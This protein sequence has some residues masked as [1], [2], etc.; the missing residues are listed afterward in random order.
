M[1]DQVKDCSTIK[2]FLKICSYEILPPTS[3]P[4]L[5]LMII[6]N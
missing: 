5:Y 3:R 1:P 6:I 2:M 4:Y